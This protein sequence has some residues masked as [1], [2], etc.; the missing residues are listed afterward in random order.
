MRDADVLL[1]CSSQNQVVSVK[2]PT[3]DTDTWMTVALSDGI[4]QLTRALSSRTAGSS[5]VP[6]SAVTT[7][8]VGTLLSMGNQRHDSQSTRQAINRLAANQSSPVALGRR[9]DNE[10]SIIRT[11]RTPKHPEAAQ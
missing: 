2:T 8:Q 10:S 11:V 7:R 4:A 6:S 5:I 9:G 3:M 1:T